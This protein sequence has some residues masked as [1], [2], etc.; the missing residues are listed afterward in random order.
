MIFGEESRSFRQGVLD[1]I[2]ELGNAESLLRGDRE[3]LG[4]GQLGMP[5]LDEALEGVLGSEV[6]LIYYKE[7]AR[8][9]GSHLLHFL[10]EVGI[11]VRVILHLGDVEEHVGIN[12]RRTAELKHLA[13]ELVV[14]TEHTGRVGI[15]HL[16]VLAVDDAHDTMAGGLRLRR[17]DREAFAHQGVHERRFTDIRVSNDIYKTAFMHFKSI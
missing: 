5:E 9:C 4:F 2:E 16:E 10:E 12:Q 3:D 7:H 6:D 11:A 15:D 8:T 1:G 13:L 17:D 14:R